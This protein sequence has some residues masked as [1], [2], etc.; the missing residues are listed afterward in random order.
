[1]FKFNNNKLLKKRTFGHF[2]SG[3]SIRCTLDVAWCIIEYEK[4][5]S[6]SV[7]SQSLENFHRILSLLDDVVISE[8]SVAR[9]S[10]FEYV[11][12]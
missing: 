1:M 6:R 11:S 2:A 5:L 4:T 7:S 9:L 10:R 12:C 8:V 3:Q